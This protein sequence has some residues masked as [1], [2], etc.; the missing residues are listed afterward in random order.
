M[1]L[2]R[3]DDACEYMDT[4]KWQRL[5]DILNS[6]GVIPL[7]GIIPECKD[8]NF[9]SAYGKNKDFWLKAQDWQR[10]GWI[11]GLHGHTHVYTTNSGGINPVHNRSEFAGLTLEEQKSKIKKAY[12]LLKTHS[13]EPKVFFAPSHT[14]DLNT[15]EALKTETGIRIISDTIANNIYAYKGFHFLPQQSGKCRKLPFKFTTIALHPNNMNERDFIQTEYF[16]TVQKENCIK[17]FKE[18]ILNNK[19]YSFY[20]AALSFAYFLKRKLKKILIHN[21]S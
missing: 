5:E 6:H 9:T 18:I 3:L 11:I 14:F 10:R 4:A 2:I 16:L 1:Y 17:D 20:D 7:V 12:S 19:K 21:K 15:L 13:L 8:K